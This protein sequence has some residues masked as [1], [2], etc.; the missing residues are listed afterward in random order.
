MKKTLLFTFLIFIFQVFAT[1][2]PTSTPKSTTQEEPDSLNILLHNIIVEYA[3]KNPQILP[4]KM[5]AL[6]EKGADPNGIIPISGSYRKLGTYI[7]IVKSYYKN[8]YRKYSYKTTPF[9]TAVSSGNVQI[10]QKLIDLGADVN[11]PGARGV[12]P[13]GRAVYNQDKE[14]TFLLLD[15]GADIQYANLSK[16]DDID[17]IETLVSK[18]ADVRTVNWNFALNDTNTL[19]RLISLNPSFERVRLNFRSVFKNPGMFDFL[20]DNGM[21]LTVRNDGFMKCPVLY[22]AV[23]FNNLPALKRIVA[24]GKVDINAE[25]KAH[26]KK[27]PLIIAIEEE[28]LEII[29]YLLKNGADPMLKDWT[30][31]TAI[32]HTV[33]LKNPKPVCKLLIEY[34]ANLEY[35][36]YFGQTPLMHA[37]KLEK[38]IAA[39]AYIELGANVNAVGKYGDTPLSLAVKEESIPLIELLIENGA[40]PKKKIKG[41]SLLEYAREKDVSNMVIEYLE[42]LN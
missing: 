22:A 12:Y 19:K 29:D 31:K 9:Y 11:T 34:G 37:V 36:D 10:V 35:N 15:N 2:Q 32:N 26:F 3:K 4:A 27:T 23:K 41:K 8:K 30:E 7:P 40:D 18:G 33:F 21:P 38:Y 16:L 13:I 6:V 20:M 25:C 24:T 1:A 5:E 39:K 17:F 28:H 14:M 42:K